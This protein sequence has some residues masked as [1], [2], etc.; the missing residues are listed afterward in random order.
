LAHLAAVRS[1]PA[2]LH[3]AI[4][5]LLHNTELALRYRR[6]SLNI[7]PFDAPLPALDA[8]SHFWD[9]LADEGESLSWRRGIF[10]R[11]SALCHI[12]RGQG[13]RAA[14]LAARAWSDIHR[15]L[16]KRIRPLPPMTEEGCV[17]LA[18]YADLAQ[19]ALLAMR[20]ADEA[21][22][23][24]MFE[25]VKSWVAET[26]RGYPIDIES[27]Y[28]SIT[29]TVTTDNNANTVFPGKI[30]L[31]VGTARSKYEHYSTLLHELR[32]AVAYAR[33]AT[34]LDKSSVR[35]DEGIAVEGSGVAAEDL[36]IQPFARHVFGSNRTYLLNALAYGIRDARFAGT[37]DATLAKYYQG[38][39]SGSGDLDTI[40]F[41]KQIAVTYATVPV[42]WTASGEE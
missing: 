40:A 17:Q 12:E 4:N 14:H 15:T 29:L 13:R 32:H 18:D 11:L 25:D 24:S 37:T 34:A 10:S 8:A 42:V 22:I 31:G 6:A 39:C 7:D 33:E 21:T 16:A 26:H 41:A 1:L 9:S 3:P 30:S 36:L 5:S 27:L 28:P 2:A 19:W 35:F 20:G 23:K 38:G